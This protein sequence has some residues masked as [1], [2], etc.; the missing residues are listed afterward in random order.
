MSR[1]LPQGWR[2]W[3][4]S[5]GVRDDGRSLR[6]GV[7][8][9]A[10]VQMRVD[11]GGFALPVSEQ[12]PHRAQPHPVH[13]VLRRPNV[14]EVVDTETGQSGFLSYTDPESVKPI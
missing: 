14:P 13:H 7:A 9:G 8:Q 11:R 10:I 4:V 6:G 12:S 3:L 5:H 2:F 1:F